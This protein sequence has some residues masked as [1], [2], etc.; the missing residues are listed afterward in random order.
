[1]ATKFDF[2]QKKVFINKKILR[3]EG[4]KMRRLAEFSTPKMLLSCLLTVFEICKM[5]FKMAPQLFLEKRKRNSLRTRKICKWTKFIKEHLRIKVF[6]IWKKKWRKMNLFFK[7]KHLPLSFP[8]FQRRI[9]MKSTFYS[10]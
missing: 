1:M 9:F 3:F 5:A 8:F 2:Y 7:K 10:L 6:P 4:R